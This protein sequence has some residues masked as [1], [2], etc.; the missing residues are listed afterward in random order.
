MQFGKRLGCGSHPILAL[1]LL[2]APAALP[3]QNTTDQQTQPPAQPQAQSAQQT[4]TERSQV[5][6]QAQERVRARRKI[7]V[8]QIIQDTYT[9][10]YEVYGGGGYLRFTPG[11]HLQHLNEAAWNAG[12]TDYVKGKIGIT[13]DFR[14]YYGTAFTYINQ[15]QVFKPSISQY[16]FLG[17]PQVRLLMRQHWGISGNALVGFGHGNFSTNTGG[18][19]GTL[20]GLYPDGTVFNLQIGAPID[21]NLGPTFAIRITPNYLMTNYGS[22]IQNNLGWNAGVVWRF[23]R[24]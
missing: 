14:G 21:Y 16:T 10:K 17:G 23:G 9:H 8:Q 12:F 24:Q 11:P 2:L 15:F 22:S 13:A 3:A 18:L 7:R 1:A 6:R 4:P 20:I 5:L 19:P